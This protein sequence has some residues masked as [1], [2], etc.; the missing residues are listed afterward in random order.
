MFHQTT[1]QNGDADGMWTTFDA[2]LNLDNGTFKRDFAPGG[3]AQAGGIL[4]LG[5]WRSVKDQQIDISVTNGGKIEN[6]G[7]LWFGADEEH[8]VGLKVFMTI[9][10]GSLDLT[11]GA[12]ETSNNDN[13]VTSDWAI[14][15]GRQF[16]K[17]DGTDMSGSLKGEQYKVNFK[18]PGTITVDAA[19]IAV[20]DV[21]VGMQWTKTE[22][23]YEDLWN[24]GILR[25]GGVSGGYLDPVAETIT[26]TGRAFANFFNVT[27]TPGAANYTLTRKEPTVVTWDGGAGEWNDDAKWNGGQTAVALMGANQAGTFNRGSDGGHAVVIDGSKPGGAAVTFDPNPDTGAGTDFRMRVDNGISSLTIKNGGTFTI[28]SASDVDGKWTR[29]GSDLTIEGTGS[30]YKRTKD[31]VNSQSG[32]VLLF[33][34]FNQQQG[35]EIDINIRDGGRLENDGQVWFGTDDSSQG[36]T[37][38]MN[39]DDGSVDLT[40]GD[41]YPLDLS[42][43]GIDP[44]LAFFYAYRDEANGSGPIGPSDETY[45]INF[46][47][48]GTFTVDHSGIY[49]V[50]EDDAGMFTAAAKTYQQLWADGVLQANGQSG[51][52]GATFGDFFSV[53]GTHLMDNYTLTSLIGGGTGGVTGDFN[54][55][56]TVD[57]ADYVLWRN[58]GELQNDP[59]PGNQ[60]GD[61]DIW[62][63]NFGRTA[64]GGAGLG[65][66]A[67]VPEPS[68]L[69]L[70]ALALVAGLLRRRS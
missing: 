6:D 58:G 61:F 47:G 24:R 39:I 43:L 66:A 30:L 31:G 19:G 27:G 70:V 35:Q 13:I 2:D 67:A 14:F 5:S 15:Y 37:V 69:A 28:N 53:T 56:G 4:M 41:N 64:A 48:P 46:T 7:Q 40:G 11:G 16:D 59:T 44:D 68:T 60:A 36:L 38:N 45:A 17:G 18:G 33:G 63:A 23:S 50:T 9:N 26:S 3:N 32:G 20:Y 25:S 12:Y 55:N 10:N 21:D 51:L 54:N 65:A 8:A 52:T 29:Q 62:K 1:A 42:A 49:A 57:A 22:A 34:A